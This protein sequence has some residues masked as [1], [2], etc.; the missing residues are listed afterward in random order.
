MDLYTAHGPVP[1]APC[2]LVGHSFNAFVMESFIDELAHAAG[3]DL[4]SFVGAC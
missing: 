4:W 2:A 1:I 3:K